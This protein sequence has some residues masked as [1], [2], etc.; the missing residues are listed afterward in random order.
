MKSMKMIRTATMVAMICM[1]ASALGQTAACGEI[2]A[3]IQ[4]ANAMRQA[5]RDADAVALLRPLLACGPNP[6]LRA[7]LGLAELAAALWVQGFQH[8]SSA[9]GAT[10]DAWVTSRRATLQAALDQARIHVGYLEVS[11]NVPRAE[12]RI[13]GELVATLPM[14]GPTRVAAGTL[15]YELGADGYV[16]ELRRVE[17]AGND[18]LTREHVLLTPRPR[19]VARPVA[20]A[21]VPTAVT[22]APAARPVAAVGVSAADV[23]A[24]AG[25]WMPLTGWLGLV[26]AAV[27]I[28]GGTVAYVGAANATTVYDSFDC[29]TSMRA[30]CEGVKGR[31]NTLYPLAL[32][33]FI[34]GGVLAAGSVALLIAAPSRGS[35]RQRASALL[36]GPGPGAFGVSCGARF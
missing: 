34:T 21:A 27:L 33:G 31:F 14:S 9:L 35:E 22:P 10:G 1:P 32:T 19:E 17:V 24:P 26:G 4:R 3:T 6:R 16:S 7:T 18:V 8:L 30:D 13:G 11:A 29:S 25:S 15:T 12:L 20:V 28:G 5:G 23:T 36:C 2:D